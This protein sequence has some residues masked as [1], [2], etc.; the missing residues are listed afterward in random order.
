MCNFLNVYCLMCKM[1]NFKCVK[2]FKYRENKLIVTRNVH[3]VHHW[4]EHKHTSMLAIGQMRHQ[5]ATAPNR[6]KHAADAVTAHYVINSGLIHT[7]LNE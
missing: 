6:A 2:I 7:L 5:S 4:H 1:C 3:I